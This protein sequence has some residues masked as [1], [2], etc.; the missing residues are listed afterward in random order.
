[1][2]IDMSKFKPYEQVREEIINSQP[3]GG[4]KLRALLEQR[5]KEEVAPFPLK[6]LYTARRRIKYKLGL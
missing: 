5:Q 4:K 6:Q 1:M 2:T 3:D